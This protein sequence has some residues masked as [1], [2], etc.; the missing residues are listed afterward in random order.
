VERG[1]IDICIFS[2]V[3]IH[4][5]LFSIHGLIKFISLQGEVTVKSIKR[6]IMSSYSI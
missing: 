3:S 5:K 4:H 6:Y 2:F 1:A